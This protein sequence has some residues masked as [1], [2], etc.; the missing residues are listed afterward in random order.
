MPGPFGGWVM[1]ITDLL[2]VVAETGGMKTFTRSMI[3][4]LAGVVMVTAEAAQCPPPTAASGSLSAQKTA[5]AVAIAN[6]EREQRGVP[7][8]RRDPLLDR[9]AQAHAEDM[10]RRRFFD[11]TTPEG[12]TFGQR[13]ASLGVP[14]RA[15]GENI[16]MGYPTAEAVIRGWMRSPGH[17]RNLLDA[18]FEF[19]GL[20]YAQ[21]AR[22]RAY[23][24][25]VF[26][27]D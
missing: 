25:Q 20:G 22:G 17:R 24:V 10:A 16:A 12:V 13:L 18:N 21:D 8:A 11:H 14:V 4:A 19:M 27:S 6:R 26:A 2:R 9:I 5:N 7:M 3:G 23:W 15:M 1:E